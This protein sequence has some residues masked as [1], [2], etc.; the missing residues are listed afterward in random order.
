[1]ISCGF[2]VTDF[3][4]LAC[5][6]EIAKGTIC[7]IDQFKK[8]SEEEMRWTAISAEVAGRIVWTVSR[9][10]LLDDEPVHIDFVTREIDFTSDTSRNERIKTYIISHLDAYLAGKKI[11]PSHIYGA[12]RCP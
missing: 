6:G 2:A 7:I 9:P 8:E 4:I 12:P 3:K 10:E 5:Y 1:M 11:H